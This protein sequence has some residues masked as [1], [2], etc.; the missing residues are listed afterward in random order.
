LQELAKSS[1]WVAQTLLHEETKQ[2]GGIH[3]LPQS[4]NVDAIKLKSAKMSFIWGRWVGGLRELA[5][6]YIYKNLFNM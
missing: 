5:T 4:S 2:G 1:N 3:E 6:I